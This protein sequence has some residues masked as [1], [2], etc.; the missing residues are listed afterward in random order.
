[1]DF[2]S[3]MLGA[4]FASL[5]PSSTFGHSFKT[6]LGPRPGFRVLTG[7]PGQLSQFFFKSKQC[8]FSKKNK[9]QQVCNRVLLGQLGCWVSRVTP[10]FSFP[11]FFFNPARFQ[12]RL[13]RSQVDSPGRVSKLCFQV[14]NIV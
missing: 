3:L 5:Y 9:S 8:Y 4:Q 11:Y 7:S 14:P 12:P 1:V 2:K 10:G 13:V 6:R